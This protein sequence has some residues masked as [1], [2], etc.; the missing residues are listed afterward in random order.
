M[1]ELARLRLHGLGG[2]GVDPARATQLLLRAEDLGGTPETPFLLAHIAMDGFALPRDPQRIDT[3]LVESAR[4]GFPAALRIAGL[5]FGRQPE[6]EY[7]AAAA[8]C[9]RRAAE[10]HDRIGEALFADR[11]HAGRGVAPDPVGALARAASLREFGIPVELPAADGTR[12]TADSPAAIEPPWDALHLLDADLPKSIPLCKG[13]EVATFEGL[14]NDEECR[15][16]IYAAAR[17]IKRSTVLDPN[18]GQEV[19]LGLRTSRDMGFL[20]NIDDPGIRMLQHRMAQAAGFDLAHCE[21]LA[22]L[23]YGPREQYFPHRDYFYP[24]SPQLAEPG[25]QRHSTV[26]VYLNDVQKGGETIFLE[27][28]VGVTPQRGRAVMFRNLYGDGKP[29]TRSLHAGQPVVVGEKW[30]A[31]CWIRIRKQR[32]H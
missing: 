23:C 7:Q 16:L 27:K 14:F 10:G 28:R 1:T 26:C 30:L 17:Y 21:P 2:G 12:E 8:E 18:T 6:A 9:L 29:D 19:A 4:R 24:S 31:S 3:W 25:G 32:Q 13:P 5:A 20:P 11:L 15:F 22:V